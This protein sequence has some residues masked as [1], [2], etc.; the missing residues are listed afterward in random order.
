MIGDTC[1]CSTRERGREEERKNE[2][3]STPA[4]LASKV[5]IS[6]LM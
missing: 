2:T 1:D 4:R 3:D 6:A 5:S